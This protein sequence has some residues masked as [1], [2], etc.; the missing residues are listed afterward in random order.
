MN[1]TRYDSMVRPALC[2][3]ISLGSVAVLSGCGASSDEDPRFEARLVRLATVKTM[4]GQPTESFAGSVV[5]RYEA[6]V[7]FQVGGRL[8]RR[9]F[10]IGDAVQ[11][12]DVIAELD[13]ADYQ[14][15]ARAAQADLQSAK[16]RLIRAE[17]EERRFAELVEPG[18][19]SRSAYDAVVAEATASREL[20]SALGA[21]ALVAD[22]ALG[23]TK[24]LADHDG[25]I[26]EFFAEEGQVLA[27]GQSVAVVARSGALEVEIAIPENKMALASEPADVTLWAEDGSVYPAYLRE[28]SPQANPQTRTYDARYAI[29]PDAPAALG[30]TATVHIESGGAEGFLVPNEA[31]FSLSGESNVWLLG[32]DMRL[33]RQVVRLSGYEQ[34]HALISHGLQEGDEIVAL[35]VHLLRDGQVVRGENTSPVEQTSLA[36]SH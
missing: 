4:S 3:W 7:G 6:K 5:A 21:Q 29:S 32:D 14:L 23:Y 20:M 19:V 30:M 35:G 28:I 36:S 11:A 33:S 12:G 24:L 2:A 9:N 8:V 34:E 1:K 13:P 27:A 22:N 16:A 10:D 18:A 17:A 26:T 15:R 25:V 31:V